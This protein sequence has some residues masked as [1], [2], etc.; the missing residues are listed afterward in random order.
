M[1]IISHLPQELRS[2]QNVTVVEGEMAPGRV[3]GPSVS[4]LPV[5]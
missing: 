2:D 1:F 3:T 5:T 4:P